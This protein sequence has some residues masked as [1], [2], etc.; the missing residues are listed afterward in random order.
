[1]KLTVSTWLLKAKEF[2]KIRNKFLKTFKSSYY[3]YC[4]SNYQND[5]KCDHCELQK[6]CKT[7][8]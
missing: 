1:M 8:K 6:I 4:F 2:Q 7:I 5:M 3:Y